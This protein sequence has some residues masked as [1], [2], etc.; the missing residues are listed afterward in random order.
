MADEA[1]TAR[2]RVCMRQGAWPEPRLAYEMLD[3]PHAGR[4]WWAS[5]RPWWLEGSEVSVTYHPQDQFAR[6]SA[7]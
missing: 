7:R 6:Q 2:A 5:D 4:H 3:G 1:I